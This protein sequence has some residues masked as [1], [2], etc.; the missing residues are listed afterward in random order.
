ML[1]L[2]QIQIDHSLRLSLG[3]KDSLS[4]RLS[5]PPPPPCSLNLMWGVRGAKRPAAESDSHFSFFPNVSET[6]Q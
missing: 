6:F 3:E 2:L 5:G 4:L 1:V